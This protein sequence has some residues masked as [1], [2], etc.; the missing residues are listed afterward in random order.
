MN[1]W[2]PINQK[3]G[4]KLVLQKSSLDVYAQGVGCEGW[5]NEPF[6]RTTFVQRRLMEV[7]KNKYDLSPVEL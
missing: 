3:N 7:F 6:Y 4:K 1:E 2:Q 5:T